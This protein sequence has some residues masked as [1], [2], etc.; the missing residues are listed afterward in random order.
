MKNDTIFALASGGG[1]AG[2]AVYRISGPRACE[3]LD[4]T[5]GLAPPPPRQARRIELRDPESGELIDDGLI[6]WFPA[7][8]SYTGENVLEIQV[9][10]GRGTHAA[11]SRALSRMIPMAEPGEFTRRAFENGKLDLTQAE[12]L[13]DLI[14]AE[15]AAQHRQAQRQLAG[16][17]GA[18]YE[19]WRK[20]LIDARA[21]LEA[22]IDFSDEDLPA[23]LADRVGREIEDLT[24]EIAQ[25]LDDGG[26]GESVRD[27]FQIAVIGPPNA[28]KSSLVNAL[29]R[30]DVA[31]TAESPGTTRDVVEVRLDIRG[32]AVT[33]CD[34]AG[35]IEAG[36][37]AGGAVE[38][39]GV[40]R[41]LDRAALADLKIALF[42]GAKWPKL[43]GQTKNHSTE[44]SILV[45]NKFDLGKIP[46]NP[47]VDGRTALGLSVLTGQGMEALLDKLGERVAGPDGSS[48][49]PVLTRL[50]H[51]RGLEDCLQCLT[52]F[53]QAPG[54]ELGA[55]DLRLAAQAL[56]RITGRV[57]VEDILDVIFAE[58]CIGK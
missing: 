1:K 30:R 32:H 52:R 41:A 11:L 35:L 16:S 34:T 44:N 25:H 58:F 53:A 39:E 57:G 33:L 19:Q 42:D 4:A 18:L 26:R 29:A 50:R 27:G 54:V 10:G 47:T 8:A 5:A 38:R 24:R 7:P 48:E 17:L 51:R 31:I 15:T 49:Q 6:L 22:E 45:I 36:G 56:G 9:H 2:I 23:G 46:H 20:K 28:G 21:M 13:A 14:E 43:D 40:R 37:E 55:E 3:V 12:G